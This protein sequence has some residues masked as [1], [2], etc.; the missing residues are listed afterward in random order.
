MT[1]DVALV[2]EALTQARQLK[3]TFR[4]G[5]TRSVLAEQEADEFWDSLIEVDAALD[6]LEARVRELEEHMELRVAQVNHFEIKAARY[7]EA[8]EMMRDAARQ[9]QLE[10]GVDF[11]RGWMSSDWV[12]DRCRAALDGESVT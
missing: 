5:E 6:R 2:R 11:R 8:L 4:N 10:E 9:R 12:E 7:R 1:D 3:W